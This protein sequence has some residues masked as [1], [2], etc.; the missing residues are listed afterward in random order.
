M[1]KSTIWTLV[2][3]IVL[4][5]ASFALTAAGIVSSYTSVTYNLGYGYYRAM[6]YQATMQGHLLRVFGSMTFVLGL[7]FMAAFIYLAVTNPKEK[8]VAPPKAKVQNHTERVK[9]A[10][11]A[12]VK[13]DSEVKEAEEKKEP[14]EGDEQ[15][16]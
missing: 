8:K 10:E 9:D 6:T 12:K 1:K 5:L 7:G 4:L 15:L 16:P 2:I 13:E 3:A 11:D 14:Q